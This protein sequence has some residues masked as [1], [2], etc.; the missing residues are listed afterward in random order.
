MNRW[1][2][3]IF[4]FLST[5]SVPIA[6]QS[7]ESFVINYSGTQ[8]THSSGV[9]LLSSMGERVVGTVANGD[10]KIEQGFIHGLNFCLPEDVEVVGDLGICPGESNLVYS[11]TLIDGATY[12]WQ[13]P[14]GLSI[15]ATTDNTLIIDATTA[16]GDF[17]ASSQ[18]ISVLETDDSVRK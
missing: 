10:V 11:A 7:L 16:Q 13:V 9:S 1:A 15:T 5:L 12:S 4:F 17:D 14:N 6:A 18:R 2:A 8:L 3:H